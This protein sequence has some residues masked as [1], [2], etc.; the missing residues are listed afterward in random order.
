VATSERIL[1]NISD[2]ADLQRI[3]PLRPLVRPRRPVLRP[4]FIDFI[5]ISLVLM[6]VPAAFGQSMAITVSQSP[7]VLAL[8]LTTLFAFAGAYPRHRTPLAIGDVAG[9][10][11]GISC[12][13]ILLVI[14]HLGKR[15]VP[16]A[17]LVWTGSA[18]ALLLVLQRELAHIF[19]GRKLSRL[20]SGNMERLAVASLEGEHAPF[21]LAAHHHDRRHAGDLLKR[22]IDLVAAAILLALATPL[23]ACVAVLI[24]IDSRGPVFVRQ[25]RIGRC[26][27]PFL[28]WKFRSMY[29]SAARYE[30]SPVSDADPRLTRFGRALRRL[31]IDELPQLLNVIRGDMSLVGPRPEMPFIVAKYGPRERLRLNAT[32]GITGLWQISPAR[33]MPIHTNLVFD[34][35]YIENRNL[36]LDI[37]ILLRTIT[38]VV[39]GI[40]AT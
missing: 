19:A 30:R 10:V 26:G 14:L 23:F 1:T 29:P 22:A 4:F 21:G 9:L 28:M 6:A 39:R 7:F 15:T 27:V 2:A 18:V 8:M 32:P 35:F 11:R 13:A 38:A 24:K 12:A 20:S 31:S 25:R 40:G 37:A 3:A 16:D 34:L 17:G 36:F 33:A 5:T